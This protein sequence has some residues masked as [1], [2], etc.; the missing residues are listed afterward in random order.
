MRELSYK[1][2]GLL[3]EEYKQIME[4]MGRE[5]NYVELGM[6]AVMWSEHCGYKNSRPLLKTFPT[7]GPQVIQGPG[8]NAGVVDIEDG[9]ALVFKIESHNHPSAIEPYQGAATGVGGIVRDI[10]TMGARPIASLNSLRF[11][12]L[13]D[14]RVRQLFSGVV[15]GI[16]GYGNCLGIPTVGGEVYFNPAYKGNPLVNAMCV[17]LVNSNEIAL[18][19]ANETG[20]PIMIVG[21]KTGRDGIHG[22][23]FASEELSE[24]SAEKRPSVQVGDPFMEKLLIEA[25]LE[26]IKEDLV[27]GMQDLGAAGLTSSIAE[28]AS[29]K[30]RGV[31]VDVLLVPRREQGMSAYEVMLSE[32][33]ERMLIVPRSG[34]EGRIK[35]IFDK[36]GLDAVVIGKVTGDGIFRVCEG[37]KTVAEVP[38]AV[39]TEGCPVYL[40]QGEE[41]PYY[42]ECKQFNPESLPETDAEKALR[43][44]LASPNIASKKWVYSQYDHQVMTNT[45]VVPGAG[46]AAVLRIKGHQ[47]GVAMTTD[48]NGRLVY[49]D[50]YQGGMLAVCEAARNLACVGARPLALT[51]CLNFG[52]PEK[53]EIYWQMQNAIKGMAEA[54]RVLNTP[55]VSGNVSLYNETAAG[56]IFPTPVVGMVGFLPDVSLRSDMA[57][58]DEGDLIVLLGRLRS[59]LGGSE[60]LYVC[61]GVESGAVPAADLEEEKKLI[62]LILSLSSASIIKSAHDISDGGLAVCLAESAI[63]GGLGFDVNIE[64]NTPRTDGILFSEA[65]GRVVVSL[66]AD[67]LDD[68]Q[69]IAKGLG[70]ETRVLGKVSGEQMVW[71]INK[72]EVIHLAVQEAAAIWG[73]AIECFMK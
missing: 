50:P 69:T 46:D 34:K 61:H 43:S 11:G 10:F 73:E 62:E 40:R 66:K 35:E 9:Q 3:D 22:A 70:I 67:K 55:V 20:S 37:E 26:L 65:A 12:E 14:A 6:F 13:D 7:E 23:T 2:M 45:S 53:P 29:K 27:D 33:Q 68:L 71:Q 52:S 36:W 4:I 57:F 24:S 1:E 28:T 54:A 17:G 41:P 16:A 5:P 64:S 60:Y 59:E 51:N 72:R 18:A 30:G 19:V 25:C 39:L 47:K 15:A 38:V 44:L 21:A 49:L 63:K 31:E 48:C 8:E 58:K 56:A 42:Q 32:S